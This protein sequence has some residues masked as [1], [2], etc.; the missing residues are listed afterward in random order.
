V[1]VRHVERGSHELSFCVSATA[2]SSTIAA[3]LAETAIVGGTASRRVVCFDAEDVGDHGVLVRIG[4][5]L[6]LARDA[7]K[8]SANFADQLCEVLLLTGRG[9][10][11]HSVSVDNG[12]VVGYM[13]EASGETEWDGVIDKSTAV[14]STGTGASL[15]AQQLVALEALGGRFSKTVTKKMTLLVSTLEG[16]K[17]HKK[18]KLAEELGVPVVSV[19]RFA[20]ALAELSGGSA[21]AGAAPKSSPKATPKPKAPKPKAA[22]KRRLSSGIST[23]AATPAIEVGEVDAAAATAAAFG[24]VAEASLSPRLD[25][26]VGFGSGKSKR[27]KQ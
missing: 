17:G 6:L 2:G 10:D 1:F 22:A 16:V 21:G 27:S 8:R 11:T 19:Q 23:L 12:V 13:G 26:E 18:S 15:K 25:E 3:R 20:E 9:I 14:C 7:A 24:T 4:G 5:S